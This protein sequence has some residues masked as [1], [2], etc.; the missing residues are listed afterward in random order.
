[1]FWTLLPFGIVALFIAATYLTAYAL[2]D[3]RR[4]PREAAK[5]IYLKPRHRRRLAAKKLPPLNLAIIRQSS[6]LR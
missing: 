2:D 3:G 4:P 1:M 6:L 5:V